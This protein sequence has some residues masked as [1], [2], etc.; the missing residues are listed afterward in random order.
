MPP[1]FLLQFYFPKNISADNY[2]PS[3]GVLSRGIIF[4]SLNTFLSLL[5]SFY[6]A[7]QFE[8]GNCSQ[9]NLFF[10]WLFSRRIAR[11]FGQKPQFLFFVCQF[12]FS[13]LVL[14]LF[15]SWSVSQVLYDWQIS[16]SPLLSSVFYLL[17]ELV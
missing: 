11:L 13:G 17:L 8:P 9:K 3:L 14:F 2:F 4:G 1:Y 6:L 5:Y 10:S 12:F 16:F 15:F 7:G